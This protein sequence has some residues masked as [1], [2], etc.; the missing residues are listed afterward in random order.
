MYKKIKHSMT[1]LSVQK[2]KGD[3]IINPLHRI[4]RGIYN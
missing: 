3:N 4:R 2:L 1:K